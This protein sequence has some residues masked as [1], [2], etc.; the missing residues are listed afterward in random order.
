MFNLKLI[1]KRRRDLGITR[2]EM[3]QRLNFCNESI[4]W[5]YEKGIYKFKAETLQKLAEILHCDPSLFFDRKCAI[6][7]QNDICKTQ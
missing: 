3:S 5:K 4:Y 6:S 7:E 2:K 1:E